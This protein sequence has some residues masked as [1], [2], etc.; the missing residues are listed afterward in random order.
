MI[1]SPTK[2]ADQ[3]NSEF[4]LVIWYASV[5]T[6][7]LEAELLASSAAD[8]MLRMSVAEAKNLTRIMINDLRVE[9]KKRTPSGRGGGTLGA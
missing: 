4:G 1:R 7:W 6:A 2:S 9:C 3:K 5:T 8:D